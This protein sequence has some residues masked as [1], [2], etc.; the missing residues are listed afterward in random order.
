[1]KISQ[2]DL[3]E[4]LA[5]RRSDFIELRDLEHNGIY[6]EK[7]KAKLSFNEEADG[8]LSVR[9]HPIYKYPQKHPLLNDKEMQKLIDGDKPNIVKTQL[10]E[11]GKK[12]K[13]I[14]E[15]DKDTNEFVSVNS[16]NVF[17]PEKINNETLSSIQKRKLKE[18]E[19]I[20]LSDGTKVQTS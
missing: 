4:M 15:F 8:K 16:K 2:S 17:V 10:D 6:I 20:E 5:G 13:I 7:L 14:I 3:S 18:G 9:V 11:L 12:Q 1:L 19:P